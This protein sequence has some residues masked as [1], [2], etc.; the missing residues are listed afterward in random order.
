MPRKWDHYEFK[1]S[2]HYLPALINGD[3]SGMDDD[4]ERMFN[5]WLEC[6]HGKARDAGW[7]VGHWDCDSGEADDWGPLLTSSPCVRLCV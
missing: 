5:R 3:T 7:H 4:D 1:I 6:M 2:G